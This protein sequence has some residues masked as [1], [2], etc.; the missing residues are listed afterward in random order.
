M[1]EMQAGGT[2]VAFTEQMKGHFLLGERDPRS[3]AED[4]RVRGSRMSFELT[5]TA[6][7]IDAFI[8]DDAHRGTAVGH[9]DCD[10]LG[11]RLPVER[12]WFDLLVD[13]ERPGDRMMVYRLH[14][15]ATSGA[16]LTFVGRKDVHDDP[17]FDLWDDTTT[18]HVQL[19]EG[20]R[21][22]AED[23]H[24]DPLLP[25]DDEAVLGAGVLRILPLDFARQLT[26]FAT[27]GPEGPAA[28]ARFGA[29]FLGRLWDTYAP[30]AREGAL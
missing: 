20:H 24:E 10:A 4:A 26:T 9:L 30:I 28:I 11:G 17:G 18:L 23:P 2:S 16:P 15:V 1:T 21:P 27:S 8:L 25:A 12:G 22:P 19:L 6:P 3:A 29:L 14:L 5:L 13:A 7:D